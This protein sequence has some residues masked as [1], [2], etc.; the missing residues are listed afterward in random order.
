[1]NLRLFATALVIAC[2]AGCS[3]LPPGADAPRIRSVALDHPEASALGQDVERLAQA[4]PGVSGFRLLSTGADGFLARVQMVRAAQRSL[5]LQYFILRGD[6]TGR[7]LAQAVIDAADRGVRVRVLIDDGETLDGDQQILA[8]NAHPNVQVRVFNPFRYRGHVQALRAVEFMLDASRLDYRMHNKLFIADNAVALIGGRNVGDEYFQ[9]DPASQFA[10]DDVFAAGPVVR[11]LSG[12]FDVFWNSALAIPAEALGVASA[13]ATGD[14]PPMRRLPEPPPLAAPADAGPGAPGAPSAAAVV[15]DLA[16]R[17][18]SGEPL[19][20]MTSG[21][22]PLAWA[23][24]QLVY[25]SPDKKS[26]EQGWMVGRLMRRPVA[27]AVQAVQSELLMI[28]PYLIPGQEGMRMFED[29]RARHV[30][31]RLLTNSLESSTQLLAQAGYMRYRAPLLSMGVDL[32]EI[33]SLLG[34][35]RGSGE[36]PDMSRY[37]HYSLHAKLFVFDRTR[38]FIGSMNFDQRS[39]HLNTEIGLIIDSPELALQM[40]RRFEAMVRPPNAYEVVIHDTRPGDA[41][42]LAWRTEENARPVEHLV[43]PARSAA[44]RGAATLLTR[45]PIDR[46]L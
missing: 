41:P 7:L 17:I 34:D 22:L 11:E 27:R 37:G 42:A 6:A 10:D 33:R 31:V 14:A 1:M 39:M 26:V 21:Q 19:R 23:P 8:I 15:A 24:A 32:F 30:R 29:L 18:P 28:T 35:A 13:G 4:H 43:E 38:L 25:D 40:V 16:R 5:D 44:Q 45:L 20:A 46:E 3:T 36:S 9:V 12:A 2:L